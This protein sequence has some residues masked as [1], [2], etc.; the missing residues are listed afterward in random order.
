MAN[1][2]SRAPAEAKK[3]AQIMDIR[4]PKRFTIDEAGISATSVPIKTKPATNAAVG[5]S[6]PSFSAL[7]GI[8]GIRP[9]SPAANNTDGK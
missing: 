2:A 8:R 6:A 7:A 1:A 4:S 9:D 5:M 3:P